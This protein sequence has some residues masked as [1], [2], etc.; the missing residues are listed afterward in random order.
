MGGRSPVLRSQIHLAFL[1]RELY[2]FRMALTENLLSH[3]DQFVRRHNGPNAAET[4]EMLSH[5]GFKS[6]NEL[7]DAAVPKKIRLEKKLK[8]PVARSEFDALAE[9][10]RIAAENKVFRSY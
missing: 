8:L 3:P 9:I 7:V 2:F 4:A 6:L 10:K 5:L 1:A